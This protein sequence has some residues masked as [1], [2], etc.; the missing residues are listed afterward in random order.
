VVRAVAEASAKTQVRLSGPTDALSVVSVHDSDRRQGVCS[1][2]PGVQ[3]GAT[4]KVVNCECGDVIHAGSDNKLVG[5][6][7]RHVRE[8]HPELAGKVSRED[9]L[10]MAE[11][12]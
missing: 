2:Q 10:A 9:I 11:D 6:V 3:G 1:T 12:T 8:A 5:K 4:S 7:E